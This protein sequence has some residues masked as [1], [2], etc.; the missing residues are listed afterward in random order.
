MVRDSDHLLAQAIRIVAGLYKEGLVPPPPQRDFPWLTRFDTPPTVIEQKLET[1]YFE[2]RM[3]AIH[4]VFHNS[5]KYGIENGYAKMQQDLVEIK[6]L[7]AELRRN[8]PA[9]GARPAKTA[10]PQKATPKAK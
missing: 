2:H 7:D 6:S 5:A 10:T 9:N 8:R 3:P 1:M 4:G